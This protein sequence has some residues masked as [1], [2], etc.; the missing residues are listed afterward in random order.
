MFSD[1]K[2]HGSA[3]V[4]EFGVLWKW[5][6]KGTGM[7]KTHVGSERC[8]NRDKFPMAIFFY[9]IYSR[10]F[11]RYC[12]IF[13][14]YLSS[15]YTQHGAQIHNPEIRSHMIFQL[16][17]PSAPT[18]RYFKSM[19]FRGTWVTQSVKHLTLDFSSGHDLN[20]SWVQA[21]CGALH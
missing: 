20:G 19:T 7:E 13:K 18:H 15:L 1:P 11:Y 14:V 6:M 12:F 16:S 17:Q 21:L 8:G 5:N 3:T 2:S 9:L 10:Y 4:Q